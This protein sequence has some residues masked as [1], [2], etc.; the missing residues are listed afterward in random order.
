MTGKQSQ[1]GFTLIELV[2]ILGLLGVVVSFAAPLI[3]ADKFRMDAAGLEISTALHAAQRNGVLRGHNVNFAFDTATSK[4]YV[5]MDADNDQTLQS[6]ETL[7][8]VQ[9]ED[10]VRFGRGGAPARSA[11]GQAA[12]FSANVAG[13]PAF[14]FFRN[15]S[16]SERGVVYLTSE[17]SVYSHAFPQDSRAIEV[18]RATGRITCYSYKSGAWATPC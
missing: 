7:N 16:A 17:R 14:R 10:G 8:V 2:V 6:D 1:R 9:L 5:H 18:E 3:D 15:G 12:T 11:G 13:L 4:L